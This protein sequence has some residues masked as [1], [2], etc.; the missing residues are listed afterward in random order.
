MIHVFN[1]SIQKVEA[2]LDYIVRPCPPPPPQNQSKTR[3]KNY[4]PI[5]ARE[6]GAGSVSGTALEARPRPGVWP[7]LLRE[8]RH[9]ATPCPAGQGPLPGWEDSLDSLLGAVV[10]V[11]LGAQASWVKPFSS[12]PTSF[13]N[14][15]FLHVSVYYKI[16]T[17]AWLIPKSIM[18]SFEQNCYKVL[19]K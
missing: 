17:L 18:G 4:F 2:G 1:Y 19:I 14:F 10:G 13:A 15:K 7:Q 8:L 6:L 16:R 12:W 5:K 11:M 9:T 3:N